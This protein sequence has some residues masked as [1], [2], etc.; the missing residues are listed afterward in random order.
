MFPINHRFR[1]RRCILARRS[2]SR[3]AGSAESS[4]SQPLA[5]VYDPN[6]SRSRSGLQKSMHHIDGSSLT[7]L[8]TFLV[9][10]DD[11]GIAYQLTSVRE[12]AVMV[13]IPVPG[14]RWQTEFFPDRLIEAEVFRGSGSIDGPEVIEKLLS[15]HGS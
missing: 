11:A 7:H 8:S 9:R 13:Q 6:S 12:G 3:R 5:D 2:F 15:T 10:L 4:Q 1:E 14:E